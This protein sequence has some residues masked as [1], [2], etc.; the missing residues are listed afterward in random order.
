MALGLLIVIAVLLV[1]VGAA[2]LVPHRLRLRGQAD[3]PPRL[4][5]DVYPFAGERLAIP[6][7]DTA[8][9]RKKKPRKPEK[10][11]A[12]RSA[13]PAS[14]W[15]ERGVLNLL[16]D[17][18]AQFRI[19][20]IRIE[21]EFGLDDPA[22]TGALYGALVPFVYSGN[23]CAGIELDIRPDFNRQHIAGRVDAAVDLVPIRLVPPLLRF[24]AK[25]GFRSRT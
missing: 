1:L 21:A 15:R 22:D 2:V 23:H 20:W 16:V 11:S 5:V 12:A 17:L 18:F 24:A 10:R 6:I 9:K 8:R 3:R 7:F 4:R 19:A 14:R 13:K 25:T